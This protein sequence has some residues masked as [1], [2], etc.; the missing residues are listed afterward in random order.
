MTY[1]ASK[2]VINENGNTTTTRVFK[3][4]AKAEKQAAAWFD[5]LM[6]A[7]YFIQNL[8]LGTF[9]KGSESVKITVL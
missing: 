4:I 2:N 5:E 8:T 9:C 1:T 7:G 3:S 6:A